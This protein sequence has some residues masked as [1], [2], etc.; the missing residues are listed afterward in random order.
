MIAGVDD[1]LKLPPPGQLYMSRSVLNRFHVAYRKELEGPWV[2][3]L[4]FRFAP[5]GKV[6]SKP[7]AAQ[8]NNGSFPRPQRRQH[9]AGRLLESCSVSP[10]GGNDVAH[11]SK[12]GPSATRR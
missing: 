2:N 12:Y 7:A 10:S 6:S 9:A 8:V 4:R 5:Y 11:R 1:V 3:H